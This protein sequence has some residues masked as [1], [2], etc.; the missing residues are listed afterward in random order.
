M[1]RGTGRTGLSVLELISFLVDFDKYLEDE[2]YEGQ[3]TVE[4]LTLMR[5]T[6][7]A[8]LG[9]GLMPMVGPDKSTNRDLG[10]HQIWPCKIASILKSERKKEVLLIHIQ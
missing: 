2:P 3:Q 10:H 1:D 6:G 8:D 4:S 7:E 9:G 5:D